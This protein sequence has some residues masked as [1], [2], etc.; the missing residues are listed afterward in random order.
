MRAGTYETR[1]QCSPLRTINIGW[2]GTGSLLPLVRHRKWR[3]SAPPFGRHGN[4][5]D[6]NVYTLIPNLKYEAT[7]AVQK[8]TKILSLLDTLRG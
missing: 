7:T 2:C 6:Y 1:P 4:K 3:R 8:A 5:A